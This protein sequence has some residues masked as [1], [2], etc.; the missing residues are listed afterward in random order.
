MLLATLQLERKWSA[1]LAMDWLQSWRDE[2]ALAFVPSS[3]RAFHEDASRTSCAFRC[4]L[5]E[6]RMRS[7]E[8]TGTTRRTYHRILAL[9]WIPATVH[10]LQQ[11][12]CALES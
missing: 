9:E 4:L 5:V 8:G 12:Q 3:Q 11:S 6:D 2:S 1:L 10:P 7:R